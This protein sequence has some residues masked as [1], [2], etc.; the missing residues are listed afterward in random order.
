MIHPDAIS[1]TF[2]SYSY[3][4]ISDFIEGFRVVKTIATSKTRPA[5]SAAD[6]DKPVYGGSWES[7]DYA[8]VSSFD[9]QFANSL[10]TYPV[11][12]YFPSH[13]IKEHVHSGYPAVIFAPGGKLTKEA[14]R[15]IGARLAHNG[16]IVLI[17][18]VPTKDEF[19]TKERVEGFKS[20][21]SYLLEKNKETGHI[22]KGEVNTAKI[23][24]GGHSLGGRSVY[25][26]ISGKPEGVSAAFILSSQCESPEMAKKISIPVQIQIGDKD[27]FVKPENALA[28]YN[29]LGSRTK[30]FLQIAGADHLQ[31]ITMR[32]KPGA[33]APNARVPAVTA[34][35]SRDEQQKIAAKYFVAWLDYYLKGDTNESD[36]LF[37]NGVKKD[38]KSGVLSGFNTNK[39]K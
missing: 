25:E 1:T 24:V 20:A 17:F 3:P 27:S 7:E 26:F 6:M 38:L 13:K 9:E 11:T 18:S 36:A 28:S 32:G 5:F 21:I 23:A 31:F 30:E 19:G 2:R 16:Y 15:W 33:G 34:T 39:A 8:K 14:Y 37:G 29:D 10:G 4:D 12:V 35:I 22:L